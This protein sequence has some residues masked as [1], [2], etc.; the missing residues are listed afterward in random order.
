MTT[1][2]EPNALAQLDL[3][4][5]ARQVEALN[6]DQT[7]R[8]V[9]VQVPNTLRVYVT[10]RPA[11]SDDVLCVR[12]D[13]GD[14]LSAG[15]PSVAFCDPETREEGRLASWPRGLTDYFKTP[16]ANGPTGWICNPWTKEGRA[17]HAEWNGNKWNPARAV[18]IVAT[19]VQ[20]ILD[21]AGAYTG[22][23]ALTHWWPR[24]T[25]F[26]VRYLIAH[27]PCCE[28]MDYEA[29]KALSSGVAD[30]SRIMR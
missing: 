17:H 4:E 16:P 26:R 24:N 19:A 6:H 14:R 3:S 25:S 7:G 20:D 12:M 29:S 28:R 18:W 10:L 1:T 15:P 2:A 11:S 9:I 27:G 30:A 8:W 5:L 21:K 23:A 22:R 13:F